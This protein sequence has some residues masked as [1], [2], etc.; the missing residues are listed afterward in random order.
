MSSISYRIEL[1]PLGD[2]FFGGENTFGENT[3]NNDNSRAQKE[4]DKKNY[5]AKS[6]RFPQQSALLGMLRFELLKEKALLPLSQN[7]D[8]ARQLIGG[9][10]FDF[11]RNRFD[12]DFGIIEKIS[13]LFL[14]DSGQDF[15]PVPFDFK[16]QDD[17]TWLND[18]RVYI[19][20]TVKTR[21]I[22]IL[23][24][25]VKKHSYES[26]YIGSHDKD[27]KP[28]AE[29]V[30]FKPAVKVGLNTI[31]NRDGDDKEAYFKQEFIRMK[32]NH[33]FAFYAQ[34]KEDVFEETKDRLIF[35][36]GEQSMFRM[37]IKKAENTYEQVCKRLFDAKDKI[38][39][40]SDAYISSEQKEVLDESTDFA[41]SDTV[42]FRNIKTSVKETTDYIAKPC[43]SSKVH[44]IK[45]GSVFYYS[46]SEARNK[47]IESITNSNLQKCGFNFYI[48]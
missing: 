3:S 38:I 13:P 31:K 40:I 15:I 42:V 36:G 26:H 43:K 35:L 44:L 37:K 25:D 21:Q 10:S 12:F 46:S 22:D 30:F 18:N 33:H 19:A 47:I 48:G 23:T 1:E 28:Y 7:K 6:T 14:A 34:L 4:K 24:Y 5:F 41:W 45:K 2:F 39:L 20:G 27:K 29:S 8:E 17:I 16:Y 9:K 32:G 11:E